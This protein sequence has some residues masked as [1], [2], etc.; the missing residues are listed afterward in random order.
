MSEHTEQEIIS[1]LQEKNEDLEN[2]IAGMETD[3]RVFSKAVIDT[4]RSLGFYPMPEGANVM[5]MILKKVPALVIKSQ[6]NPDALK[7]QFSAFT[8]VLPFIEKYK[9]LIEE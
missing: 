3:I 5:A 2:E 4:M 6:T 7:E 1:R 9:H 8:Q